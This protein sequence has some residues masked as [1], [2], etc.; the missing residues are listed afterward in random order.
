MAAEYIDS[1]CTTSQ[2]QTGDQTKLG[3]SH[4]ELPTEDCLKR[5]LNKKRAVT[6]LRLVGRAGSRHGLAQHPWASRLR[7]KR[8]ILAPGVWFPERSEALSPGWFPSPEHRSAEQQ[9]VERSAIQ[10]EQA[11]THQGKRQPIRDKATYKQQQKQKQST[12]DFG[13]QTFT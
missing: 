8:N 12:Q 13:L 10:G 3:N 2:N 1:S 4:P 6:T 9:P 5:K 7:V 11:S